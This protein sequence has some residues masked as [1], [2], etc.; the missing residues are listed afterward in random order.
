MK[1]ENDP[2]T[3]PVPEVGEDFIVPV[4]PSP[5]RSTLFPDQVVV[6]A[7]EPTTM[8]FILLRQEVVIK[9]QRGVVLEKQGMELNVEFSPQVV[10]QELFDIGHVRMQSPAAIDLAIGILAQA[11]QQ[12]SEF[13]LIVERLRSTAVQAT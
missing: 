3:G 8:D 12:G 10:R 11:M 13:D 6:V 1:Q 9:S 7:R 5:T 2:F 4:T